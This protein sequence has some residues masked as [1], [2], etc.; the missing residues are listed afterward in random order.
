MRASA[1]FPNEVTERDTTNALHEVLLVSVHSVRCPDQPALCVEMCI[2]LA[3]G[4]GG[5]IVNAGHQP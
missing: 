4:T 1:A 3:Y 5:E 2:L